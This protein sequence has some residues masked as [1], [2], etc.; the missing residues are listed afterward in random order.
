MIAFLFLQSFDSLYSVHLLQRKSSCSSYMATCLTPD[1]PDWISRSGPARLLTPKTPLDSQLPSTT[2][3]HHPPPLPPKDTAAEEHGRRNVHCPYT[4]LIRSKRM[5]DLLPWMRLTRWSTLLE[6]FD[7]TATAQLTNLPRPNEDTVD[8]IVQEVCVSVRDMMRAARKSILEEHVDIRHPTLVQMFSDADTHQGQSFLGQLQGELYTEYTMVWQR[9]LIFVVRIMGLCDWPAAHMGLNVPRYRTSLRMTNRQYR[10]LQRVIDEVRLRFFLY[11]RWSGP[12]GPSCVRLTA[13]S[14]AQRLQESAVRMVRA[15]T[16]LSVTLIFPAPK[17]D[18]DK[19][20]ITVFLAALG[21]DVYNQS[22][23]LAHAFT[24]QL[25]ALV[26]IAHLAVIQYH[27]FL[28][29]DGIPDV[30]AELDKARR[31][32]LTPESPSPFAWILKLRAA[33][34]RVRDSF[35][36]SDGPLPCQDPVE[37]ES[38]PK[39]DAISTIHSTEHVSKPPYPPAPPTP[40]HKSVAAAPETPLSRPEPPSMIP[41]TPFPHLIPETPF[42]IV[43]PETP[44]ISDTPLTPLHPHRLTSHP[45]TQAP[46]LAHLAPLIP[47]SSSPATPSETIIPITPTPHPSAHSNMPYRL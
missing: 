34:T 35:T 16:W 28:A 45:S 21:L 33:G 4:S 47:P 15:T 14:A 39:A 32:A 30:Y 11:R 10:A 24:P 25:S 40:A 3:H 41:E 36:D 23:H 13:A 43:I 2:S 27:L 18:F 38:C 9:L 19:N 26:K 1:G 37:Q 8:S 6:G 31:D 29:Q 44:G 17:I 46:S 5:I 42:P 20:I 7:L 12:R 22:F